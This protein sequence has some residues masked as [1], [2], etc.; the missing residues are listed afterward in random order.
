MTYS[1]KIS[2]K[3]KIIK[4]FKSLRFTLVEM[5]SIFDELKNEIS[6]IAVEQ[7][8]RKLKIKN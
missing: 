1:Q 3:L 4:E 5:Y 8:L 7:E 2:L 6:N